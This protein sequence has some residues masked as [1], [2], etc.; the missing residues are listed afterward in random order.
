VLTFLVHAHH[1]IFLCICVLGLQTGRPPQG[2]WETK[3]LTLGRN[4]RQER[5][6]AIHDEVEMEYPTEVSRGQAP[7]TNS[8][9]VFPVPSGTAGSPAGH[10]VHNPPLSQP[11]KLQSPQ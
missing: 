1:A 6:L 9:A 10:R 3:D 7:I 5:P 11:Y 8:R 4:L 2:S